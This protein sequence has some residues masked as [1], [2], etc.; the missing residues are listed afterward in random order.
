MRTPI[1]KNGKYYCD[2]CGRKLQVNK[3]N[4]WICPNDP[5]EQFPMVEDV[6]L[7][8]SHTRYQSRDDNLTDWA[9][10]NWDDI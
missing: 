10:D 3:L 9:K 8:K 5:Y 1:I 2:I 6:E 7:L 4:H